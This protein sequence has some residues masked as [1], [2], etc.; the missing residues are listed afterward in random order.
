MPDVPKEPPEPNL[1]AGEAQLRGIVASAMDAI[2]SVDE[3]QRIVL[4]NAAAERMFGYAAWETIGQSLNRFI[5][6]RFH[7]AHR[8]HVQSFGNTQ[9]THR[10]M[11]QLGAIVGLRS[12]GEEFPIEAAISQA[13]V[14]GRKLFTVILR[15]ISFRQKTEQQQKAR[16]RYRK[17]LAELSQA[18]LH[19]SELPDLM[20]KA[21]H[22]LAN[23]L[24]VPFTEVLEL[25]PDHQELVLR[26]GIGWKKGAVGTATVSA[27]AQSSHA[28]YTL[29]SPT[30]VVVEDLRT[31]S[32]FAQSPFLMKHGVISG[33]SALIYDQEVPYGVLGIHAS[34]QRLFSDEEI[35]FVENMA[36]VLSEAF[37]RN[38]I[39]E[40]L[41]QEHDFITAVL[42]TAG[43]LVLVLDPEGRIVNFNRACERLT[44]YL[45][46]EM[47]GQFL[48]DRLI[49]PK[50]QEFMQSVFEK[51]KA[52][53]P[54]ITYENGWLPRNGERRAIIWT[55]TT[56]LDKRYRVVHIIATGIDLTE[57]KQSE[58]AL[59]KAEQLAQL[60][61]LASGLAHEIGTPLN[62]ILGR[63]EILVRKTPE[64]SRK[65]E[66]GIIIAQVERVTKLIQQLLNVARRTPVTFQPVD[67]KHVLPNVLVL[68]QERVR[69]TQVEVETL[70]DEEEAFLTHGNVDQLEQ[71]FLNLCL[72][73]LQAM[74]QGG[75][76]RLVL[77]RSGDHVQAT[78]GDTG[79]G[80]SKDHLP[81]IFEPF[82][83][84]KPKGEGNGLGLM[85]S[86]LIV[87]E[88]G[89][90]LTVESVVGHGTTFM[91]TL[92]LIRKG[93]SLSE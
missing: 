36:N 83:S 2:I 39:E 14:E 30:P 7:D 27:H 32:R 47:K 21:V 48:W 25:V 67:V 42:D 50:E 3:T 90:T 66:L 15:D 31:E 60:G 86:Q 68:L 56:L 63:A 41:Q 92:P 89:G 4:F 9:V 5:P 12:N 79:E 53:A 54:P 44:G 91:I 78:V 24:V 1:A 37:R 26:Y 80:I 8:T 49:L 84:T 87:K 19:K 20:D 11:G 74:P 57:L 75:V 55:N 88:H 13:E 93:P 62:I 64:E 6:E 22:L 69:D 33:I 61:T 28:G 71:V 10:S 76:L 18:A 70:W 35:D 85:M 58:E 73:A 82:F 29:S 46:E 34:T 45:A 51:L 59:V 17:A 23:A 43:A 65:K 52:G 77:Q 72:N 16:A 81:K 38:R 40:R